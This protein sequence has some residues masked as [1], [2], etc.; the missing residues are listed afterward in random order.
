MDID[1]SAA[2]QKA[3]EDKEAAL[4]DVQNLRRECRDK[5]D[6]NVWVSPFIF[7]LPHFSL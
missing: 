7:C 5:E 3:V 2:F 4:Q 1:L 6:A